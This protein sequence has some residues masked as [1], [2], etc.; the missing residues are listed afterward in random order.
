MAVD[1][2]GYMYLDFFSFLFED[3]YCN[4][5]LFSNNHEIMKSILAEANMLGCREWALDSYS[6]H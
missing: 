2:P 4:S 5:V 1:L 3:Y 6:G